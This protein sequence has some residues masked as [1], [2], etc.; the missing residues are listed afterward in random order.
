LKKVVTLSFKNKQTNKKIYIV[1]ITSE[2]LIEFYFN[3]RKRKK[4]KKKK[5]KKGKKKGGR[6]RVIQK[7]VSNIININILR[8][9]GIFF[10]NFFFKF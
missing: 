9:D 4:K 3:H 10:F 1:P 7:K 2:G 8:N 5:K 6:G